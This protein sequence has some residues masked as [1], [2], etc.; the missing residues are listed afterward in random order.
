MTTM[1]SDPIVAEVHE[2]RSKLLE[3]YG[4]SEGYAEHLRQLDLELQDR[5]VTREPRS[6]AKTHREVSC[7]SS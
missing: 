3:K 5:L 7:G 2:T 1:F 4:G 6:P